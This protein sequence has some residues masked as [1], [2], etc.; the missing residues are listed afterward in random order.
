L[1][2]ERLEAWAAA[3]GL[4]GLE[5]LTDIQLNPEHAYDLAG[6]RRALVVDA[7]VRQGAP[8]ALTA[9]T[10]APGI[11]HSTHSVSPGGVVWIGRDLGLALPAVELLAVGGET[12]ELGGGLSAAA[13]RN[14]EAAWTCLRDWCR[15][16]LR[17]PANGPRG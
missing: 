11:G 14:L 4:V 3:E 8:V 1:L 7:A 6:R 2:A 9:V 12:F 5:V 17:E 13:Q 15:D 10:P 16:A